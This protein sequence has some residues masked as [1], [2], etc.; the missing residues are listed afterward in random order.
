MAIY[1][2]WTTCRPQ[3]AMCQD[4]SVVSLYV[5]GQ[6]NKGNARVVGSDL[7]IVSN[8]TLQDFVYLVRALG[9]GRSQ[10]RNVYIPSSRRDDGIG[11]TYGNTYRVY[12]RIMSN[13]CVL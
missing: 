7:A 6:R 1:L 9:A 12:Y 13:T 10:R 8:A 2:T 11:T 3:M 5:P 4:L